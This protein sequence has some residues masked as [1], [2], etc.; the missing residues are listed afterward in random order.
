MSCVIDIG[1]MLSQY[2]L[3]RSQDSEGI[4]NLFSSIGIG[5]FPSHEVKERVKLYVS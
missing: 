3:V 2:Y 1:K 4:N 5:A